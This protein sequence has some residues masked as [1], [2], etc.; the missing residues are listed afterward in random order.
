LLVGFITGLVLSGVTAYPLDAELG[1]LRKSMR[2]NLWLHQL[3]LAKRIEK[4]HSALVP[5]YPKYPFIDCA[6]G[7]LNT[8]HTGET[9]IIP[10]EKGGGRFWI[11]T[12]E[13]VSQQIYSLLY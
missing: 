10:V 13:G 8:S 12:R 11:R 7:W 4:I 2:D 1:C 5:T 3:G 9:H 6:T